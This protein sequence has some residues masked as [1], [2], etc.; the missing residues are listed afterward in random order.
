MGARPGLS[1]VLAFAAAIVLGFDG[2]A[3]AA[4]GVWSRRPLLVVVGAVLFVAGGAVLVTWRAQQR[5]LDEI[6][7]ARRELRDEARALGDFLRRN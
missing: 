1:R 2:T 3:L 6:A 5:R 4:L 7:A